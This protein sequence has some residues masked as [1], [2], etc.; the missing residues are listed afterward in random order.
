MNYTVAEN[1]ILEA[2][3]TPAHGR[4]GERRPVRMEK[5]RAS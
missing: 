1:T 2:A 5:R 3:K 4:A